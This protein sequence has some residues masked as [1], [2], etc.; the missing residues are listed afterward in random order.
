MYR[1]CAD[2]VQ[3]SN[4]ERCPRCD[5]GVCVECAT[6][7]V[8]RGRCPACHKHAWDG[9]RLRQ[10]QGRLAALNEARTTAAPGV[11]CNPLLFPRHTALKRC[12]A[13]PRVACAAQPERQ[14]Q[15]AAAAAAAAALLAEEAAEAAAQ[16][17]A[18]QKYVPLQ[19]LRLVSKVAPCRV[20]APDA[21]RAPPS[22]TRSVQEAGE[23]GAREGAPEG[24]CGSKRSC[25]RHRSRSRSGLGCCG[26]GRGASC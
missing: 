19:R 21:Q 7:E 5:V 2:C 26:R 14:K 3:E 25:T 8:P 11:L 16:A 4:L 18:Q 23:E 12:F 24:A 6:S 1:Q 17:A 13:V 22:R 9:A 20:R 15:E 10:I